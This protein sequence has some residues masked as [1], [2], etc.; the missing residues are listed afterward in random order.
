MVRVPSNSKLTPGGTKKF[1][2]EVACRRLDQGRSGQISGIRQGL[3]RRGPEADGSS[4]VV[5]P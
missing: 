2:A 1:L 5:R 3:R 4:A